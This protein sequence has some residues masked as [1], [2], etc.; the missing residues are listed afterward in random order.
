[1]KHRFLLPLLSVLLLASG[2][3]RANAWSYIGYDG[4]S[5]GKGG[6]LTGGAAGPAALFYNPAGLI[7][8]KQREGVVSYM[9]GEPLMTYAPLRN[10]HF[11]D[12]SNF[13]LIDSGDITS[14]CGTS[15]EDD[16]CVKDF[17][18]YNNYL[19]RAA[20]IGNPD[21]SGV[22][23]AFQRLYQDVRRKAENPDRVN[24][25]TLGGSVPLAIDPE[26]AFA[27]AGV[28]IFLPLGPIIYQRIK[29]PTTPYFLKYDDAPHR[30]VVDIG[31]AVEVMEGL[32]LG[33]GVDVLVDVSAGIDANVILPAELR[34]GS[35]LNPQPNLADITFLVDGFVEL[36]PVFAPVAG[37]QYSPADWVD[38]GVSFRD[39]QNVNV[40]A[41]TL[42]I[43]DSPFGTQEIPAEV[44]TGGVFTPRQ[45]GGGFA[46]YPIDGLGLF[47]D[48]TWKQWS[49]YRPPFAV[50]ANI[51][52]AGISGGACDL[53]RTFADLEEQ[54][55]TLIPSDFE[56]F[57]S[58][59]PDEIC[60]LIDDNFGDDIEISVW[61]P[62]DNR[63]Q[64]NNTVSPAFGV[65]YGQEK[66][67][68]SVGYRYE[69]TPV[70]TQDGIFNI[71]DADT[72]VYSGFFEYQVH[73]FVTV[74]TYAQYR[75]ISPTTTR[76]SEDR[77]LSQTND[78]DAFPDLDD[79]PSNGPEDAGFETVDP[80]LQE[81]ADYVDG[82]QILSPGY[83]GYKLSGGYLSVGL[84]V[85]V[86][87]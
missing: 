19:E 30:I 15:D 34:I 81:L 83:P 69:P 25:I 57:V 44:L 35:L 26:D 27:A 7:K 32:R 40:K 84:Q 55:N 2:E 49:K 86:I 80:Q 62:S 20:G 37:I 9:H 74:G 50:E 85:N 71:L 48:A 45:L 87:F 73:S 65:S 77:V 23:G 72:H 59:G 56:D 31:G 68:G 43:L 42:L 66:W 33:I 17:T 70:P 41:D 1:M 18:R 47:A 21:S 11:L 46:F 38:L 3:A 76:K 4:Q 75:Q 13:S 82:T 60:R 53:I 61:D 22:R 6:A 12:F 10:D 5:M 29:G 52:G 36:P 64:L 14:T 39:Q 16:T 28:S 8:E 51:S 54:I 63:N 67:E 79:E 58:I 24:G 78:S